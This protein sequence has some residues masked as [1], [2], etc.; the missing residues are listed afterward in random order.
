MRTLSI[1]CFVAAISACGDDSSGSGGQGGGSTTATT[2]G[3]TTGTTTGSTS[4]PGSGGGGG[5]GGST[6]GTGGGGGGDVETACLAF[7]AAYDGAAME[8]GCGDTGLDPSLCEGLEEDP[9]APEF[10]ALYACLAGEVSAETC[11]C[12]SGTGGSGGGGVGGG[13]TGASLDCAY[14]CDAAYDDL[15]TCGGGE[16]GGV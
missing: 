7:L 6:V 2:S 13:D 5:G 14:G 4:G 12:G 1:L 15:A 10:A 11:S 8:L 9:C 16:G 3:T